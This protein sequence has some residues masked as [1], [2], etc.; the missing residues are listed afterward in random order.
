MLHTGGNPAFR[1][2]WTSLSTSLCLGFLVC[3]KGDTVLEEHLVHSARSAGHHQ[4]PPPT[5]P[6]AWCSRS[7]FYTP[8][9][10]LPHA[11]HT[12]DEIPTKRTASGEKVEEETCPKGVTIRPCVESEWGGCPW[13]PSC[14][15][16]AGDFL[17]PPTATL[18]HV[19]MTASLCLKVA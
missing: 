18:S 8:G 17:C 4:L 7:H 3:K 19:L 13:P 10:F 15:G 1:L 2:T 6:N 14:S 9:S 16:S 11:H 12:T 5:P